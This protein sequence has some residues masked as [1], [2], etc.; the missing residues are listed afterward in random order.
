VAPNT[1]SIVIS[2]SLTYKKCVSSHAQNRKLQITVRFTGYS[3]IVD[4]RIELASCHPSST[5]NLGVVT[6][7]IGKFVNTWCILP[8]WELNTRSAQIKK[9]V[10]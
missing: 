8:A 10:C 1:F 9:R 7:I 6:Y 5:Y 2:F 4:P 3:R